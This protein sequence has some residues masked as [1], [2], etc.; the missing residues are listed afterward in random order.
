[1]IVSYSK[2]KDS[3]KKYSRDVDV[4]MDRNNWHLLNTSYDLEP[5]DKSVEMVKSLIATL[6]LPEN[7]EYCF[8]RFRDNW[9]VPALSIYRRSA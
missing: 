8:R 2:I 3:L 6:E 4:N 5:V 1:M 9:S 7:G